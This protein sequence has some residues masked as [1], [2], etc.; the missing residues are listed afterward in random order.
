MPKITDTERGYIIKKIDGVEYK[1]PLVEDLDSKVEITERT[2]TK[3]ITDSW[4]SILK[5]ASVDAD[6]IEEIMI[7]AADEGLFSKTD[8]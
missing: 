4:R 5:S 7:M 1:V 3:E 8:K 6:K 2:K